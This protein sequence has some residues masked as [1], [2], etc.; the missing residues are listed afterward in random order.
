ME[1]NSKTIVVAGKTFEL[2]ATPKIDTP[3][4]KVVGMNDEYFLVELVKRDR[5]KKVVGTANMVFPK[6]LDIL[7]RD[8]GSKKAVLKVAFGAAKIATR[9]KIKEGSET[10]TATSDELFE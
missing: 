10:T 3:D 8:M 4:S 9:A 5:D 7:V 6:T 2:L 1:A